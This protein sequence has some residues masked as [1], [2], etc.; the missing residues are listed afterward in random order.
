MK[1]RVPVKI[2]FW[3]I[4]KQNHADLILKLVEQ[5]KADVILLAEAQAIDHISLEC[6]LSKSINNKFNS[7]FVSGQKIKLFDNL[8][9][10]E[11]KSNEDKRTSSCLYNINGQK[12]LLV[13]VHLRDKYSH[14]PD[15][16]YDFAGQHRE[17]VD[18]QNIKKTIIVGDFNMNP[19]E[20]G[21]MGANGFNAIMSSEEIEYNPVRTY[22]IKEFSFYYNPSWEGYGL[23]FPQ[24]TYF[25][26][27]SKSGVNPYWHL[28]DQVLVS[29]EVL[30]SNNYVKNSFKII[31]RIDSIS[32]LKTTKSRTTGAEKLVPNKD[33]YSDHLPI[34]FEMNF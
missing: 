14:N 27:S 11:T 5:E 26:E 29:A 22:G 2:L 28:L 31:T 13:G 19:Y 18:K 9:Y 34:T 20:K 12:V 17:L 15:D 4:M 3:N 7:R 25:Y 1:A 24:G 23:P 16:L 8:D 33:L 21:I 10:I 32:L 30:K 6:E